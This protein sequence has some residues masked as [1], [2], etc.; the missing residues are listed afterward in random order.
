MPLY[1]YEYL[2]VTCRE[3]KRCRLDQMRE[4]VEYLKK[5][6][7]QSEWV[8]LTAVMHY[9]S[10][11]FSFRLE[12]KPMLTGLYCPIKIRRT[13]HGSQMCMIGVSPTIS[14]GAMRAWPKFP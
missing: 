5:Q 12:A 10:K 3:R 11:E 9:A 8:G 4:A 1:K 7:P 14:G 6:Q 13:P 2:E